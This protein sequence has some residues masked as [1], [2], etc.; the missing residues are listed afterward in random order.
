MEEENKK[1]RFTVKLKFWTNYP[2]ITHSVSY[3]ENDA[4]NLDH[5]RKLAHKK[6]PQISEGTL[7]IVERKDDED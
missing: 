7:E 5:A 1:P 3:C 4:D 2:N 6:Y